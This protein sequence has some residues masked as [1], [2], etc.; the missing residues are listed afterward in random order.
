[1][2]TTG[3]F[4]AVL[5]PLAEMVER[6]TSADMIDRTVIRDIIVLSA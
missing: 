4:D 2:G 6:D 5:K 1:M 3:M